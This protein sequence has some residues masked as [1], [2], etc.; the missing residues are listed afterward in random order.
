MQ[1]ILI[2]STTKNEMHIVSNFK[3][4]F[5]KKCIEHGFWHEH[6]INE[7]DVVSWKKVVPKLLFH[8]FL[9]R[10]KKED[11]EGSG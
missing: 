9:L 10:N 6:K 7:K 5:L 8:K 1:H 4:I 2:H 3:Y 11:N